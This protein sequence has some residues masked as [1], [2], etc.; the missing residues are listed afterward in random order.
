MCGAAFEPDL[1]RCAVTIV[2]VFDW[3][4]MV[5][6]RKRQEHYYSHRKLVD[7]LGDPK[8]GK[9]QFEQI[10]PIH[11]V[12][13]IR[14]PIFIAHGNSDRNV[15]VRQSKKRQCELRRRNIPHETFYR[16]WES[17]GFFYQKNRIELYRRI[18]AFLDQ[19]L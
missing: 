13:K 7:E 1:Y 16:A 10:S 12:D 14:I 17:H 11:H 8:A 3:K 5:K 2:G 19:H 6:D 18:E 9:E 4:R 15:S